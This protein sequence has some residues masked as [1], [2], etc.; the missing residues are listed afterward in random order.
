MQSENILEVHEL[1]K[2]FPIEKGLFKK[3]VGFAKA[4]DK[5][6]ISIRRVKSLE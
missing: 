1:I 4:V 6:S 3:V 5:I 2:Y